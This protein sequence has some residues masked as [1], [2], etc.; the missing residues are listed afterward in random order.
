MEIENLK[1]FSITKGKE[2]NVLGTGALVRVRVLNN[3]G[4]NRF[5]VEFKGRLYSA[6]L[7]ESIKSRFFLA[8][9][10]KASPGIE[11]KFIKKLDGKSINLKEGTI[12]PLLAAKKSF[13]Q[14][15]I[16]TDIFFRTITVLFHKDRKSL[17]ESVHRSIRNQNILQVINKS[18][19]IATEV[20][21]YFILQ[22][23]Y[24]FVSG[25]SLVLSFPFRIDQRH[26]LCNFKFIGGKESES[27]AFFLSIALEDG[28]KI[29]FLVFVDFELLSC[30]VSSND[31]K[32]EERLKSNI[33]T[34]V[35]DLKNLYFNREVEI[36]FTQYRENNLLNFNLLKRIDIKM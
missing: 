30:T 13:I 21:E 19:K 28:R 8:R 15:L 32:L 16:A 18:S 1:I 11:L 23:L 25:D 17:K 33:S 36:H 9:I 7:N 10:I 14:D 22:N 35:R 34:L 12:E 6:R 29:G 20:K 4:R 24:N 27:N 3:L 2:S 5:L 26:Y 31:S